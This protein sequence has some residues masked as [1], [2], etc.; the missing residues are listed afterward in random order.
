MI[1]TDIMKNILFKDNDKLNIMVYGIIITIGVFL[2]G[3]SR[4]YIGYD[5][6]EPKINILDMDLWSVSHIIVCFI[7]TYIYPHEWLF[8]F[9]VF[10]CWELLEC[11]CGSMKNQFIKYF[12]GNCK[13]FNEISNNDKNWFYCR[14]SDILANSIGIGTALLIHKFK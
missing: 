9:I 12:I 8:I 11:M 7:L 3:I 1:K 4:C 14:T 6:L 10:C 2:I 13:L 5:I